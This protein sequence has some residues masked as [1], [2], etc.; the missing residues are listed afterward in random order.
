MQEGENMLAPEE[1]RDK[2]FQFVQSLAADLSRDD[3][4]LPGFPD[5]VMQ[6]HTALSDENTSVKDIVSLVNAE[7]A[8][9]AQLIKLANSAAF[10]TSGWEVADPRVAVTHLGF[11]VVRSTATAFAMRQLEQQDWLQPVRPALAVIWSRSN[12]VAAICH[13]LGK[14]VEGVKPDE[15]MATGLFHQL[16]NLYLVTRAHKEGIEVAN[17]PSWEEV[18]SGWHPTI[19][20]AI[21]ENWGMPDH[22][23]EAAENQDV[24]LKDDAEEASL[25]LLSR[26]LSAAKLQD[27][28]AQQGQADGSETETILAGVR[29][30]GTSFTDL[31]TQYQTDIDALR[32]S[33]G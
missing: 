33:I 5:S 28:L 3:L 22:V 19:A 25:S 12:G 29:L 11:N 31:V 14:H 1:L 4:E 30:S 32:A 18:I 21:I 15:A 27:S 17:N 13:A 10:N 7:P 2:A 23:A 20:R 26:L 8:L 6:L 24:L 9:A 16:G